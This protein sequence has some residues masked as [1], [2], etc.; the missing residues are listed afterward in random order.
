VVNAIRAAFD[1]QQELLVQSNRDL[2]ESVLVVFDQTFAITTALNL[3]ATVVAFIGILSALASLQLE[4]TREF[5]AM[6]ANGM[7][8]RQLFR[9]TLTETGLMGAIAAVMAVPV[10]T[11][12]AWVLV[13]I[14]NLRSFG[15]T[16]TLGLRPEFYAQAALVALI[17]SLLAGV[18]PALRIG[19]IQ[20][21]RALRLE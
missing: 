12:L 14:I 2:R 19:Q 13:Y 11:V 8:R 18:Y 3:L 4:R 16:L 6:R 10:G 17:A 15:W 20:P 9:L 21:A 7:T 1:G 5:G